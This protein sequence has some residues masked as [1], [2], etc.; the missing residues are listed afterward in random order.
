M[1]NGTGDLIQTTSK[2]GLATHGAE[3]PPDSGVCA[4]VSLG[5]FGQLD[6]TGSPVSGTDEVRMEYDLE[7]DGQT[8][9]QYV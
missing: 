4:P 7:S 5:S 1:S 9:T 8:W 6:D 2:A 3:P